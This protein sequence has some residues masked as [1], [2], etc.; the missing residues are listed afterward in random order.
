MEHHHIVCSC[1]SPEHI[2]EF[3]VNDEPDDPD[4]FWVQVQLR[5]WRPWWKRVWVALRY[6]FGYQ[7]RYG[8][9]DSAS[10]SR[11]E[12]TKLRDYLNRHF[13]DG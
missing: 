12:A 1:H 5:Q 4:L 13:G 7:C 2:V 8:H 3:V 6:V 11:E 10:V 9:W